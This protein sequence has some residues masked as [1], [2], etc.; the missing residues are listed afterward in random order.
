MPCGTSSLRGQLQTGQQMGAL[1][2]NPP[3]GFTQSFS[4]SL[5]CHGCSAE[6][7]EQCPALVCKVLP[8]WRLQHCPPALPADLPVPQ[9]LHL[10]TGYT[11]QW[12]LFLPPPGQPLSADAEPS[13]SYI[14][15]AGIL[16]C[17]PSTGCWCQ[18]Q[19]CSSAQ[20]ATLQV[21]VLP[22]DSLLDAG[23]PPSLFPCC[24]MHEGP[25]GPTA[26]GGCQN[27]LFTCSA[28]TE[29]KQCQNSKAALGGC[30]P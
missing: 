5:P 1:H 29:P 13:S 12:R 18:P 4:P 19:H 8:G 6:L 10:T 9:G 17:S 25:E 23:V 14:L 21:S 16:S 15:G 11:E 22:E 2:K 20:M 24:R 7:W 3:S 28:T 27:I 26:A 30:S